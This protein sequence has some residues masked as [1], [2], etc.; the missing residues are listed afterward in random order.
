[1]AF[2]AILACFDASFYKFLVIQVRPEGLPFT[3]LMKGY[4]WVGLKHKVWCSSSI[5]K[6][7]PFPGAVVA[8]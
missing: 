5:L 1:M 7:N 2:L 3:W 6:A 4:L 8:G